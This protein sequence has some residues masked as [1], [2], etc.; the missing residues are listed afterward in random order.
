MSTPSNEY[1]PRCKN[2]CCKSMMVYGEAFESDPE[3]IPGFTD[4]WC[5]CTS[6]GQGPDGEH[7][8]LDACS[9]PQRGC[10]QAY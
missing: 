10:Y 4:F 5:V 8:A 6:K 3:Y 1:R 7:V 9:D 2:L